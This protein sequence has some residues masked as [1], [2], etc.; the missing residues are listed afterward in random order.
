MNC[1]GNKT[2]AVSRGLKCWRGDPPNFS[3]WL[4]SGHVV[5][6][7]HNLVVEYVS[8]FSSPGAVTSHFRFKFVVLIRKLR[9]T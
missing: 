6:A 8:T 4:K 2:K 1:F 5:H 9:I 7:K 3:H